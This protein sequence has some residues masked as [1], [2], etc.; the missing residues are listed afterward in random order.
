MAD[1]LYYVAVSTAIASPG[2]AVVLTLSNALRFGVRGAFGGILGIATGSFVI[3]GLSATG[4]GLLLVTSPRVFAAL[5]VAGALYLVYL[6]WRLWRA[7][8]TA[9]AGV[10]TAAA[11]EGGFG[12][13]FRA[14]VTMQLANPQALAFFIALF[15][16]FLEGAASLPLRFIELVLGYAVLMVLI[17]GAYVFAAREVQQHLRAGEGRIVNR[18]AAVAFVIFAAL[19]LR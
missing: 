8:P 5:K 7:P 14:G 16:R 11:T 13:R 17:H 15:P 4:L 6:A 10:G 1:P 2:P 18:L 12:E 19:I 9:P 3:A